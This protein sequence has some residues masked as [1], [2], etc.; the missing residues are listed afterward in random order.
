MG[1]KDPPPGDKGL[2]VWLSAL[3]RITGAAVAECLEKLFQTIKPERFSTDAAKEFVNKV[4]RRVLKDYN[5]NYHT[6][7]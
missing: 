7:K 1:P 6:A 2:K 4:V 3:K 5:V